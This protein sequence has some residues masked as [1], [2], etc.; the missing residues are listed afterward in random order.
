MKNK[1]KE[2]ISKWVWVAIAI[3]LG[4]G[5]YFLLTGNGAGGLPQPPALPA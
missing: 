5:A 3:L 1:N 4:I 2:G